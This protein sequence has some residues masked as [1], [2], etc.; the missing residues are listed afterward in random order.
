[1][2]PDTAAVAQ[3]APVQPA[4]QKHAPVAGWQSPRPLQVVSASHTTLH[5]GPY[6]S[7][8][9]TAGSTA[10]TCVPLDVPLPKYSVPVLRRMSPAS[11]SAPDTRP[12]TTTVTV[13]SPTHAAAL[14]AST[15]GTGVV[16]ARS[17]KRKAVA[18]PAAPEAGVPRRPEN[19]PACRVTEEPTEAMYAFTGSNPAASST[20]STAALVPAGKTQSNWASTTSPS[21]TSTAPVTA[22]SS[23]LVDPMVE[24]GR[25]K[26]AKG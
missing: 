11:S 23:S 22:P 2:A 19:T 25:Q 10:G 21:A 7:P 9:H 17:G 24:P 5:V 1:M 18:G 13:Q 12:V 15:S 4:W 26:K 16:T 8:G 14:P 3:S 20:K 6:V